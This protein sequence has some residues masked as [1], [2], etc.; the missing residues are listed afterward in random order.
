MNDLLE[1]LA[2]ACLLLIYHK[3]EVCVMCS[4]ALLT[5]FVWGVAY[6]MKRK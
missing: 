4:A 6:L 1:T 3:Q 2:N 5:L